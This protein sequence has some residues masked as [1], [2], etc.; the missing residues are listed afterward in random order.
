MAEGF[1]QAGTPTQPGTPTEQPG[2]PT[3][4]PGTPQQVVH[5]PFAAASRCLFFYGSLNG[6]RCF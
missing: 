3:E 6:F 4:Q 5:D 1:A 2:T